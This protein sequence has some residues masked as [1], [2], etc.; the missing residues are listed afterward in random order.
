KFRIERCIRI[1]KSANQP[2]GGLSQ[3]H[4][5]S[6][7]GILAALRAERGFCALDLDTLPCQK[8]RKFIGCGRVAPPRQNVRT[9]R[10]IPAFFNRRCAI[11]VKRSKKT[12]AVLSGCFRSRQYRR[13]VPPNHV[14]VQQQP[15]VGAAVREPA[16]RTLLVRSRDTSGK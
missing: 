10:L 9:H 11:G 16:R 12:L 6:A 5:I 3:W 14:A 8:R 2:F 15:P 1:E 7:R 4:D 13:E